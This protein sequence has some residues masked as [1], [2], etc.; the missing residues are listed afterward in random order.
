LSRL[1]PNLL[2]AVSCGI[3][4]VLLVL[5]AVVYGPEGAAIRYPVLAAVCL[6][7]FV[8][9]NALLARR[10]GRETLPMISPATPQ[11]AVWAAIFPL[12]VMLMAGAPILW[13]DRDLGLLVIIAAVMT[14]VTVESALKARRA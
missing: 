6:V 9:G 10:L 2:L 12:A 14:G 7:G 3:A 4:L 1:E 8:F 13:P 11:T 5:S